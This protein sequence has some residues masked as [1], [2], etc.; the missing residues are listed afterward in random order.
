VLEA[1]PDASSLAAT[2][3]AA[4]LRRLHEALNDLAGQLPESRS[5]AR[6]DRDGWT[7]KHELAYLAA[8][9]DLLLRAVET[10]PGASDGAPA[11]LAD[12]EV[13]LRRARGEAMHAAKE[14]RLGPLREHLAT[15]A[16]A[17]ATAV[18]EHAA[19][20]D[21]PV[22]LGGD[23]QPATTFLQAHLDRT[24]EALDRLRNAIG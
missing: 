5:Y 22:S 13:A 24:H 11:V 1:Q 9:N 6:T 16:G 23:P 20:L 10:L 8:S 19:L 7:V 21:R 18:E 12:S 3:L 17:A 14:L 4:E 15:L 2:G